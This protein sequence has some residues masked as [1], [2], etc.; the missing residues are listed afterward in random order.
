[1]STGASVVGLPVRSCGESK[2]PTLGVIGTAT[3]SDTSNLFECL[4][5]EWRSFG[6]QFDFTYS[7][8][9]CL[10]STAPD[11]TRNDTTLTLLATELDSALERKDW[12]QTQQLLCVFVRSDPVHAV[13]AMCSNRLSWLAVRAARAS[14]LDPE[15]GFTRRLGKALAVQLDSLVDLGAPES[16][17]QKTGSGGV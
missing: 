9:V 17:S 3:G 5:E 11:Q 4:S 6:T 15:A 16:G 1:M 13:D 7:D 2:Q 8:I 14:E 10:M 12:K